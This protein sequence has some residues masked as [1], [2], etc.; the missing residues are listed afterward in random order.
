MAKHLD[1]GKTGEEIAGTHLQRKGYTI[2]EKNYRSS[3]AEVDIIAQIGDELVF[4]E[5]KTRTSSSFGFPEESI[6][7]RKIELMA[8]AAESY[9]KEIIW[10]HRVRFDLVSIQLKPN[11]H[12]IFHV[13]DAFIPDSLY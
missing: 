1:T 3:R 9:T 12:D 5:V 8:L 13:E 10:A 6:T 4:V 2:L 11:S 7:P